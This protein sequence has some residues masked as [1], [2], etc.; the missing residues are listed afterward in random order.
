MKFRFDININ[1]EDYL[2]FHGFWMIRSPY[3][4][5]Q[6]KKVRIILSVMFAVGIA[7]TMVRGGFNT[8][9]YIS[10]AL[11]IVVYLIIQ[12]LFTRFLLRSLKS[13][14]KMLKKS[15]K[16][17]YSPNA[18]MEFY[19]EIFVE[20]T[21]E[22]RTEQSY[23]AV[24]RVSVVEDRTIYIHINNVMAYILPVTAFESKEQY[25]SFLSFIRTKCAIVD[26]Y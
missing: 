22:N 13:Q 1:D 25:D 18:V 12:A 21:P 6:T 23:S 3:G 10:A 15:G 4:K 26:V 17:G 2:E 7:I 9:T 5:K 14:L 20:T 19:D 16:M 8:D 11:M 24:E